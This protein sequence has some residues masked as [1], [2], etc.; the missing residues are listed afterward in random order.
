MLQNVAECCQFFHELAVAVE[1]YC[2]NESSRWQA[3]ASSSTAPKVINIHWSPAAV[4]CMQ[5]VSNSQWDYH[6]IFAC[7]C[8][9]PSFAI[10]TK[11]LHFICK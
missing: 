7:P 9:A 6:I 4:P 3:A 2:Q 8:I 11:Q 5:Q 10:A 1:H